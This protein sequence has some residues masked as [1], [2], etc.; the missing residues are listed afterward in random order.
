LKTHLL[1]FEVQRVS[2][3]LVPSATTRCIPRS[4]QARPCALGYC[5]GDVAKFKVLLFSLRIRQAQVYWKPPGGPAPG[6]EPRKGLHHKA[7]VSLGKSAAAQC[8][9]QRRV[10]P[11]PGC[12]PWRVAVDALVAP[13]P[14]VALG[15]LW[16]TRPSPQPPYETR[17]PRSRCGHTRVSP[18]PSRSRCQV[19]RSHEA[20]GRSAL[21]QV[22]NTVYPSTY[23]YPV[24]TGLPQ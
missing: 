9:G 5:L 19:L 11:A 16:V 14:W 12:K 13:L 6:R 24:A 3:C 4:E 1:F 15:C 18:F 10:V 7:V 17:P 2:S 21:F 22:S 23:R 8:T 20:M